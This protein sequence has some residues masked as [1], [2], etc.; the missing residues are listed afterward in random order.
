[1][2]V[3]ED[4]AEALLLYDLMSVTHVVSETVF[5]P[6]NQNQFDALTSFTFNIGMDNFRRSSVL[7]RLNEGNFL[8]A[9]TAM[10]LWRKA[11]FAG[12]RIVVDAL[13]RRRAAE[14]ALFLTPD[15]GWIPVSTPVLPPRLDLVPDYPASTEAARL[16]ETP[17]SNTVA[18]D[19]AADTTSPFSP[20]VDQ[21]SVE[22]ALVTPVE[23]E[24]PFVLTSPREVAVE[25]V[26]EPEHAQEPA[27][28]GPDL[29]DEI[30]PA[31]TEPQV[32]H[33]S[34]PAAMSLTPQTPGAGPRLTGERLA[35]LG[36]I[37]L[38]SLGVGV[39]VAAVI[40]GFQ[41]ASEQNG[42]FSPMTWGWVLGAL[43]V[44][45]FGTAAYFLLDRMNGDED[46]QNGRP[47]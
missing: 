43:A 11:D 33:I 25:P 18:V 5:S 34:D 35:F 30:A 46:D 19:Q 21:S 29:F 39:F 45:C 1:M 6:L 27:A 23:A 10:E 17:L 9:A 13:V 2:T 8:K 7:L 12:E 32:S 47:D 22:S 15:E 38:A 37:G 26:L 20:A 24:V 31:V 28:V 4:D 3:S 42:L 16:V 36:L 44:A 14:K 40:V 41:N